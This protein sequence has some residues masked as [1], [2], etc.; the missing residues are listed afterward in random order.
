MP[1]D[2][3][4]QQHERDAM[5]EESWVAD[6]LPAWF[7]D[8]MFNDQWAFGLLLVTGEVLGISTIT[9]VTRDAN[10]GLWLDVEMLGKDADDWLPD[11]YGK[12]VMTAPTKRLEASIN[13]AHVVCAFELADT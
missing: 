1:N 10:G 12:A 13:A 9:G 8:R 3:T 4:Y 11:F 7:C 2:P 6:L 5:S